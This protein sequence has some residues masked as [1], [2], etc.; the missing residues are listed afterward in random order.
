VV[1]LVRFGINASLLLLGSE[2]VKLKVIEKR[3]VV[4]GYYPFAWLNMLM[5]NILTISLLEGS[6]GLLMRWN[7]TLEEVLH[8]YS[9]RTAKDDGI[10]V[11][12][13]RCFVSG[14]SYYAEVASVEADHPAESHKRQ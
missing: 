6:L 9:T 5:P 1:G 13:L 4:V 10:H 7:G 12:I 14:L 3:I 8:D 11:F 2:R